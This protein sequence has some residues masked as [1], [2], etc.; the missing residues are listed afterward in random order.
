MNTLKNDMIQFA[1][2]LAKKQ[3]V[4]IPTEQDILNEIQTNEE[5]MSFYQANGPWAKDA[6]RKALPDLYNYHL[7]KTNKKQIA[8]GY[9]LELQKENGYPIV[10]YKAKADLARKLSINSHLENLYLSDNLR[11]LDFYQVLES[12]PIV[13][14]EEKYQPAVSKMQKDFKSLLHDVI[15][16]NTEGRGIFLVGTMGVGKTYVMASLANEV[17]ALGKKVIMVHFPSLVTEMRNNIGEDKSV[18]KQ[19]LNKLCKTD[20]LILDDVGAESYSTWVRDDILTVILEYRM[21]NNL[22]TCFNSNFDFEGYEK[23]LT[24]TGKDGQNPIKAKRL[25]E[26]VKCLADVLYYPGITSKRL[27][28]LE[29]LDEEEGQNDYE[30]INNGDW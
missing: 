1:N 27:K 9:T 6:F 2:N 21:Q 14:P 17:S 11:D 18:N 26:R 29:N 16:N 5:I 12:L 23:H 4:K 30:N 3:N 22:F 10:V 19:I 15:N 13:N 7:F 28:D 24:R 25:M 8:D 20:L